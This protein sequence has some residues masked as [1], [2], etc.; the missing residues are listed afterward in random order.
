MKLDAWLGEA[1][2]GLPASV[3]SRLESEYT[4]HLEDVDA[5]ALSLFGPPE[6]VRREFRRLYLSESGLSWRVSGYSI[7]MLVNLVG[8]LLLFALTLML[9][10]SFWLLLALPTLA[11]LLF[12]GAYLATR[13]LELR[14]RPFVMDMVCLLL[15][16]ALPLVLILLDHPA[17]PTLWTGALL[18]LGVT[19]GGAMLWHEGRFRRTLALESTAT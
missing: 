17:S 16:Y 2:K 19:G 6:Q 15:C 1:T 12:G 10:L 18:A 14:L 5:D 13:R 11:A 3:R 8:V 4:A 9:P 7:G